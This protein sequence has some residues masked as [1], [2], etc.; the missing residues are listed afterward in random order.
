[1]ANILTGL[2]KGYVDQ[3]NKNS[4][5]QRMSDYQTKLEDHKQDIWKATEEQTRA[6]QKTADED[7]ASRNFNYTVSLD[8][9]RADIAK[10]ADTKFF[11]TYPGMG[12]AERATAISSGLTREEFLAK[13]GRGETFDT[14]L[15]Q[16]VTPAVKTYND[17]IAAWKSTSQSY[18]LKE[19]DQGYQMVADALK[20]KDWFTVRKTYEPDPSNPKNW[21]IVPEQFAPPPVTQ[22]KGLPSG[23]QT[24]LRNMALGNAQGALPPGALIPDPITPGGFIV[25]NSSPVLEAWLGD[26]MNNAQ[27]THMLNPDVPLQTVFNMALAQVGR[28]G[29]VPTPGGGAGTPVPVVPPP[30]DVELEKKINRLVRMGKSALMDWYNASPEDAD[31]FIT[32]LYNSGKTKEADTIKSNLANTPLGATKYDPVPGADGRYLSRAVEALLNAQ[33]AAK[34]EGQARQDAKRKR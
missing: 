8:A 31:Q 6:H 24:T 32:L 34:A 2:L 16:Y 28:F 12:A 10:A 22:N 25:K 4:Y 18:G 23:D 20:E 7:T 13:Q 21:R 27:L 17:R 26:I 33:Q 1:M 5:D 19:T 30:K 9:N 15:N 14:T 3:S 29:A 11:T